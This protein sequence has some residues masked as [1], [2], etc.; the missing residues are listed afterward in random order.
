MLSKQPDEILS[1]MLRPNFPLAALLN[2]ERMKS[3]YEWIL[4]MTTLLERVTTCIDARERIAMIL[5]EVPRT[6]Y[7]EGVYDAVRSRDSITD[8]LRYDFLQLFLKMSNKFLALTPYSAS[9]LTKIFERIELV[10]TKTKSKS[11]VRHLI[12]VRWHA[13]IITIVNL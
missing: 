4:H 5:K 9:D 2:D 10:F 13:E 11:P 7:L 1:E 6:S 12:V 8:E 3:K